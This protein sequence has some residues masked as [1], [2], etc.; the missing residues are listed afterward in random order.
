[1]AISA[2]ASSCGDAA[3]RGSICAAAADRSNMQWQSDLSLSYNR[4]GDV[5]VAQGNLTGALQAY[6]D[7]LAIRERL[8]KIEPS[9]SGWQHH[10]SER[11]STAAIVRFTPVSDRATGTITATR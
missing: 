5:L 10:A 9:N 4:I 8:A 6:R 7:S 1:M 3:S 2:R 11:H